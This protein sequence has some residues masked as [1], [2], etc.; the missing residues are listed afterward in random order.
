[1]SVPPFERSGK[2]LSKRDCIACSGVVTLLPSRPGWFL[3]SP[4]STPPGGDPLKDE[5]RVEA[6]IAALKERVFQT[7]AR[8][9]RSVEE[10]PVKHPSSQ[11]NQAYVLSEAITGA[12]SAVFVL[13]TLYWLTC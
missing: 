5:V 2:P 11:F 3:P 8:T 10:K 6:G 1:M 7:S 4:T 9:F 12:I 13:T